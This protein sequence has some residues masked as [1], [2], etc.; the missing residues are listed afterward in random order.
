MEH[1]KF[2]VT[3]KLQ[4]VRKCSEGLFLVFWFVFFFVLNK[5]SYIFDKTNTG[6]KRIEPDKILL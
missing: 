2:S 6:F 5:Y 3:V 4:K 1:N